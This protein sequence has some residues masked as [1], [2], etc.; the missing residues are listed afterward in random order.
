MEY[1]ARIRSLFLSKIRIWLVPI[2]HIG[3]LVSYV[4]GFTIGII[5]YLET[6]ASQLDTDINNMEFFLHGKII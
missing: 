3:I 6:L 4:F 1:S 2:M 5:T